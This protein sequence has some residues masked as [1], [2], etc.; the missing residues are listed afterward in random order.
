M[1][2]NRT[3]SPGWTLFLSTTVLLPVLCHARLLLF[4]DCI[5]CSAT[6][7]R[8]R[9]LP[10][11]ASKLLCKQQRWPED[12]IL[13]FLSFLE[14]LLLEQCDCTK[15]CK[16]SKEPDA[17]FCKMRK[18]RCK[19]LLNFLLCWQW[20]S[21]R[22]QRRLLNTHTELITKAEYVRGIFHSAVLWWTADRGTLPWQDHRRRKANCRRDYSCRLQEGKYTVTSAGPSHGSRTG[23]CFRCGINM[24]GSLH[25]PDRFSTDGHGLSPCSSQT[26]LGEW[27]V[28]SV[29]TLSERSRGIGRRPVWRFAM[30]CV[31]IH[32][33]QSLHVA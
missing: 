31:L 27:S 33:T 24:T 8:A 2:H 14:V 23:F 3:C 4:P 17:F 30:C 9:Y 26:A 22:W 1:K 25:P 12:M 21:G 6:A 18:W 15:V 29:D 7:R 32:T 10:I 5:G 20:K 28:S 13:H 19:I 11:C 16:S